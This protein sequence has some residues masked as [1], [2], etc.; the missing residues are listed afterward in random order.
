MSITSGTGDIQDRK[1]RLSLIF[2][3][4]ENLY[5]EGIMDGYDREKEE[6]TELKQP[7]VLI[8]PLPVSFAFLHSQ[9]LLSGVLE[10]SGQQ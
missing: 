10:Y 8:H 4:G 3:G 6:T 7:S 9:E 5:Q 2:I 1:L